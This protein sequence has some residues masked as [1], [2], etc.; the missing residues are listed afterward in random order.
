MLNI[1]YMKPKILYRFKN[2]WDIELK[3]KKK[4]TISQLFLTNVK[5]QFT[6]G[7]TYEPKACRTLSE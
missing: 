1:L 6:C 4:T 7:W 5:L 3:K 2:S